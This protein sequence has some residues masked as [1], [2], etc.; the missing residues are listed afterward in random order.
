M[1]VMLFFYH[2]KTKTTVNAIV[3]KTQLHHMF[4]DSSLQD[5]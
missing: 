5:A 4:M 1:V 3:M 2:Q